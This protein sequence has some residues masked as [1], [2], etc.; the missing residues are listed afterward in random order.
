[1]DYH[2]VMKINL[3]P[4]LTEHDAQDAFLKCL[5]AVERSGERTQ[6]EERKGRKHKLKWSKTRM[7]TKVKHN[8]PKK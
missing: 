7:E 5:R 2:Y 1:M 3:K 6:R 4:A 8:D